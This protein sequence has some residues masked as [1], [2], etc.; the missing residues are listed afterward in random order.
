MNR[1]AIL[2]TVLLSA[3]FAVAQIPA[4]PKE[5]ADW[6]MPYAGTFP[7]ISATDLL[8]KPAGKNGRVEARNGH[9]YTGDK[10]IRFW[11][12]NLAFG[13][14]FPT[15]EQ[16]VAVAARLSTF[17]VNAV[18]FHHMDNQPFP[19]GIFADKNLETLSPEALD[20]LDYFIDALAAQGVYADINLH[21]SRNWSK[22]HGLP[23]SD[24]LP[25]GYDKMLDIF[26]P[27]L[28]AANKQYARNLLGHENAYRKLRYA[29]DPAVCFVEI[30]NEDTL[31]LWG[32]E[33]GL[34]KLPDPYAN[35]LNARWNQW[36]AKKYRTREKLQAAW[37]VG[38]LPL[39]PEMLRGATRSLAPDPDYSGFEK[40]WIVEKDG[41]VQMTATG[42]EFPGG[43]KPAAQIDVTKV[44][45][46]AWHLQ[47][48]Q[49]GLKVEKGKFYTLKF[50][51]KSWHG[52][53]KISVGVSQAHA[54]WNNL[55][56][57][58][59]LKL[60]I[61]NKPFSFGFIATESDDN[62]RVSFSVGQQIQLLTLSE[63]SLC[64]GGRFGLT[65]FE[66][67][68]GPTTHEVDELRFK[69]SFSLG[70]I[71]SHEPGA[72]ETPARTADWFDFLQQTDVAYFA[73]MRDF[74]K[75]DLDVKCPITGTI[76]LGPLGTCSQ[77][78]MDFVDAHAY[79]DH[80]HFPHK[81]W[82]MKDWQINNE[83]MVDHPDR[84]PLF[85]LAAT[86]VLGKPFTVTEYNHAAP[87]EWAAEGV[88]MVASFA[89][90][91]DWDA[92]FLFAYSHNGNYDKQHLTGFFDIEGDPAKMAYMPLAARMF[93]GRDT[94]GAI[95]PL[96]N[97][98][99]VFLP[100]D[101][102][103]ATGSKYYHN[104]W[105]FVREVGELD[106]T[107]LLNRRLTISYE[108]TV[109]EFSKMRA[110]DVNEKSRARLD[111]SANGDGTGQ[112]IVDDYSGA[113]FAGFAP[114]KP[115]DVGG[116]RIESLQSPFASIV[117]VPDRPNRTTTTVDRLLLAAVARVENTNMKRSPDRKTV[118]TNWGKSPVK[119]EVVRGEISL[120]GEKYAVYAITS[121]GS[122]GELIATRI[123]DG[124]C[125]IPLGT[126]PTVWYEIVRTK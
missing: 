5:M 107:T 100:R 73:D 41:D 12:V 96:V 8:E 69:R 55:G 77:S 36:L 1:I 84:S 19:N 7:A 34:A 52:L 53:A 26:H 80:P 75:N 35:Q 49:P 108:P 126:T 17:G 25:D 122:R 51:A 29:D 14:C 32:G 4:P 90:L 95:K 11:G 91:Q 23:N 68:I 72:S 97:T 98:K 10:R 56:L 109:F 6:P 47:F 16:A 78:K 125:V 76:G 42:V 57:S 13:A 28:I 101:K 2:T 48:H 61:N 113:V 87:N 54:P 64:E 50:H 37:A 83:P 112:Y 65:Q 119:I 102:M 124:R 31:F 93:L 30:N 24:K 92:V 94:V 105:P 22:T 46:T 104:I 27:D 99:D 62:A 18:R 70:P 43:R 82:D 81:Q 44:D 58:E 33:Q 21:V 59:T 121:E 9:F 115:V 20:R 60:D 118:G 63:L 45:D 74:L 66:Q 85:G 39:G 86:H 114:K 106:W 117:L 88:P 123:V 120:P 103:L 71:A 40:A 89:A 79:W 67:L 38:E 3:S 15:H 110:P 116:M 111:W